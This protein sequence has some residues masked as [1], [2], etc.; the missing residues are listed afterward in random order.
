MNLVM[1][2]RENSEDFVNILVLHSG[3]LLDLNPIAAGY[4]DKWHHRALN[5]HRFPTGQSGMDA[6][7]KMISYRENYKYMNSLKSSLHKRH[8]QKTDTR[9]KEWNMNQ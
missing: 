6:S 9:S 1:I 7:T 3:F 8:H 4:Q 2:C 5:Y